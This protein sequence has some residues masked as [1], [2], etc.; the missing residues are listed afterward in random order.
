LADRAHDSGVDLNQIL[1]APDLD[2]V[3]AVRSAKIRVAETLYLER[4]LTLARELMLPSA[5]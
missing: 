1:A 2:K 3:E 5:F 4:M